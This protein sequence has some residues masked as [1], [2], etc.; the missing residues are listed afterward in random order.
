VVDE[1]TLRMLAASYAKLG[2]DAGYINTLEKLLAHH[3]KKDYWADMLARVQNKP[4]FSDRLMLDVYRLQLAT[5]T[6]DDPAQYLEMAQLALQA[7]LPAE[8]KKVVDAGYAAGKLGTGAEAE[9]HRRLRELANKQTLEDEKTLNADVIGRNAEALVNTGQALVTAGRI[10]RGI[11]LLEH[12]IAKGGLKRPE[13][14]K[15]HLGQAYLNNGNKAKAIETFKSVRGGDGAAD[16]AR[17]WII[18]AGRS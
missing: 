16:L 8:A 18:R 10:D 9:R 13:D 6:L 12:G 7:G 11:E 5:E 15:L 17:L 4:G 1:S 14:A 3:P 2:D